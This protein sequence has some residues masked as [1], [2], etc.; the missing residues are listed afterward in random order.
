M[1]VVLTDNATTNAAML[2]INERLG[3][4]KHRDSVRAQMSP[5]TLDQYL[6]RAVISPRRT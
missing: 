5:E 6:D 1:T 2:A 3:F 4:E